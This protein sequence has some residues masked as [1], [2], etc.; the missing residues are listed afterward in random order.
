MVNKNSGTMKFC[1]QSFVKPT[2][3]L[4]PAICELFLV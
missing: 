2:M 3:K 4:K 1:S